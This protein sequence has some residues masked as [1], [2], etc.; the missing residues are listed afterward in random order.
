MIFGF[1]LLLVFDYPSA[2]RS[3]LH[4]TDYLVTDLC[5]NKQQFLHLPWSASG[6]LFRRNSDGMGSMSAQ[7]MGDLRICEG[8]IDSE[9]YVWIWRDICC[10]QD[11][12]FSQELHVYFSRTM[13]G[14]ILHELQ[15]RAFIGI[16]CVC[17]TGLPADQ[18][19]LLF[20]MYGA[21]WSEESD[22]GDH[23]LLSSSSLVNSTCKTATIDI[24]ISQTLAKCN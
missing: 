10:C 1:G 24:F 18:I 11:D 15:Q 17:L 6:S 9:A 8:N 14:L 19:C 20:K 12:D 2:C 13:P 5:S 7:G 21:S 4:I 23:G 22:N 3:G 16:E